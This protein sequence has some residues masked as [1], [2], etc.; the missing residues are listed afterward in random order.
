L[1]GFLVSRGSASATAAWSKI[2]LDTMFCV[3]KTIAERNAESKPRKFALK[4][5]LHANMTPTVSGTRDTYVYTEYVWRRKSLYARTVKRGER[6]L[7]VWTSDTGILDMASL[8]RMWPPIMKPVRGNV[9]R[10]VARVGRFMPFFKTA[11][12]F[13]IGKV[14]DIQ[15]SIKHQ[16]ETDMNCVRVRVTGFEYELSTSFDVV[17]EPTDAVYQRQKRPYVD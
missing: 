3:T 15:P 11:K 9:V 14:V 7:I 13:N 17:L 12:R 6:P 4:S 5:V 2:L 1:S 8:L 10:M 16:K